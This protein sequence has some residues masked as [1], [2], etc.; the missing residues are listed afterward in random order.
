MCTPAKFSIRILA[1]HSFKS[2]VKSSSCRPSKAILNNAWISPSETCAFASSCSG[3]DVF[4]FTYARRGVAKSSRVALVA[5]GLL[6]SSW[7]DKQSRVLSKIW[8][9][10][11]R[12][13][14]SE[15]S[16]IR[17]TF[18]VTMLGTIRPLSPYFPSKSRLATI[19]TSN[20]TN[21]IISNIFIQILPPTFIIPPIVIQFIL[22]YFF[23][24]HYQKSF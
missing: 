15:L 4:F 13:L 14:D 23:F 16:I 3:S 2:S 10:R 22:F 8:R 21:P 17:T 24:Y 6:L 11:G 18:S 1:T 5:F 7:P 12:N 20:S 9:T 19:L